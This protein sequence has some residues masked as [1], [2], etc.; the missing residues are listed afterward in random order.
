MGIQTG[1]L[2]R[3]RL[4]H[5]VSAISISGF[6][7]ICTST[8]NVRGVILDLDGVLIDSRDCWVEAERVAVASLGGQW[9]AREPGLGILPES[10]MGLTGLAFRCGLSGYEPELSLAI[11]A[12]SED[13]FTRMVYP[14]PGA[15]DVLERMAP[16]AAVA[17]ATNTPRHLANLMLKVTGL[18]QFINA[19]V[20]SDDAERLK[21]APDIY[22]GACALLG[23]P[24][25]D[26]VGIDDTPGGIQ[27]AL[28]AGLSAL[29]FGSKAAK[30]QR[31][32]GVVH[33]FDDLIVKP[34]YP[35]GN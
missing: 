22:A 20:C 31:L 9:I 25:N 15:K 1:L 3:I 4:G 16:L 5:R 13:I 28:D 17:V 33:R 23:L 6:E 12:A 10:A 14:M 7:A 2:A 35:P 29:A 32:A 26:C 19:I 27:S 18:K 24:V 21:P 8:L 30:D 34:S 11:N